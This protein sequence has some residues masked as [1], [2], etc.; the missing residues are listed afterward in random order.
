MKIST[1]FVV[2]I[3]GHNLGGGGGAGQGREGSCHPEILRFNL[4]LF[5]IFVAKNSHIVYKKNTA[6]FP[7]RF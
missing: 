6:P 7:L 2:I 3:Q 4:F 5:L 1:F